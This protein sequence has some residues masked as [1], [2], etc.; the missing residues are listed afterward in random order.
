MDVDTGEL[1]ATSVVHQ[2]EEKDSDEFVKVFAA[3]IAATYE[4][5]RTGQRVFQAILHE[6]EQA[7]MSRGFADSVFLAWFDDGLTGRDIGMSEKT[8]KED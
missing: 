7:P 4:L 6:Y 3:G 1:T 8:F 5:T 2:I